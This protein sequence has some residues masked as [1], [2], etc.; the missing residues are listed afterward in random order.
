[1]TSITRKI[2][3]SVAWRCVAFLV[4]T[5]ISYF[6]TGSVKSAG[7]V[8]IVYTGLQIVLYYFHERLWDRIHWGRLK[9][10]AVQFTGLSGAGKTTIAQ[11]IAKRMSIQGY[12]I[13]VIDGDEYRT[14]L[15]S[16]LGF[17]REDRI[18]NIRRLSFV[19]HK[20]ADKGKVS[21]IAAIN[22]YED[23]R[24]YLKGHNQRHMT[25]FIDV[26]IDVVIQRDVKGLYEKALLPSDDPNHIPQ[27]TGI[28]DPFDMP[29]DVDVH[30]NTHKMSLD[31]CARKIEKS[32]KERMK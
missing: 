16:D 3:K 24:K 7:S 28:S 27:F 32:I 19:A 26:P 31:E 8:A 10:V 14:N 1:M 5:I 2:I 23:S 18:E 4:L 9:G 22:P 15:C 12:D 11:E 6:I 20:I 21:I 30:V 17:S 25:V 13:E 29:L